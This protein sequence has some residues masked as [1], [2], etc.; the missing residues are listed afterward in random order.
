MLGVG[1]GIKSN[2]PHQEESEE[3]T[4]IVLPWLDTGQSIRTQTVI[5]ERADQ[6]ISSTVAER[7]LHA[8]RPLPTAEM[9]QACT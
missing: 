1:F 9:E 3:I 7:G 5:L 8:H 4:P 6:D 2:K